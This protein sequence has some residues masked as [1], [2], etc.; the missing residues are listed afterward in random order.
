MK[1]LLLI[2]ST[3]LLCSNLFAY[4]EVWSSDV[5]WNL[6]IDNQGLNTIDG[7]FMWYVP[8]GITTGSDEDG[9]YILFDSATDYGYLTYSVKE[10]IIATGNTVFTL[11]AKIKLPTKPAGNST[12]FGF[13]WEE[14]TGP[15]PS[16]Q[17]YQYRWSPYYSNA[18]EKY[19]FYWTPGYEPG[20]LNELNVITPNQLTTIQTINYK[21]GY[22]DGV[23]AQKYF[24]I[25]EGKTMGYNIWYAQPGFYA[26]KN[27][28]LGTNHADAANSPIKL[29]Q[30]VISIN[31]DY[32]GQEI[33][34]ALV[35]EM[36][37]I[38]P[39]GSGPKVNNGV[40]FYDFEQNV[41]DALNGYTLS[42]SNTGPVYQTDQVKNNAYSCSVPNANDYAYFPPEL[43][44]YLASLPEWNIGSWMYISS[45]GGNG[46]MPFLSAPWYG[47]G[48][49]QKYL[50]FGFYYNNDGVFFFSG[51]YGSDLTNNDVTSHCNING[52]NYLSVQWSGTQTKFYINQNLIHTV[53]STVNIF[54]GIIGTAKIGAGIYGDTFRASSRFDKFIIS[55]TVMNGVEPTINRVTGSKYQNL[56][57]I[58]YGD[59]IW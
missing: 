3:I 53:N 14:Y 51:Y 57:Q 54:D 41:N 15:P 39:N 43:I 21:L 45:V 44:T 11:Q 47:Y 4:K 13:V 26:E 59:R 38:S 19:S 16:T 58:K 5:K 30:L 28:I 35:P 50:N 52:W 37:I 27:F 55:S 36:V 24:A 31:K 20:P 48:A 56:N 46:W 8:P 22:T 10:S 40:A 33:T 2:L 49:N 25:E 18:H 32:N 6:S 17:Y 12:A 34:P 23:N 29:Y 42:L 9:D 7:S 1:K